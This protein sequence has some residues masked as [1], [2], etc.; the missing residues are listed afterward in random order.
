M[1]ALYYPAWDQLEMRDVPEPKPQAGEVVLRVL[2]VGICGSELH[3][4]VAHAA[5]RTP[6]LIMGH[7]FSGEITDLGP[8]VTEFRVGDRVVA[9]SQIA[10][11]RCEYCLDGEPQLC[12]NGEVFGTKRPGAFA[13]KV[14]VPVST[15][16]PLP[17]DVTPLQASLAE[18][19]GNAVHVLRLTRQRF[20]ETA[21]VF[22]AG[23]IGLFVLQVL[24][25]SGALRVLVSDVSDAR[26]AVAKRLGADLTINA[27]KADIAAAARDASGGRGADVVVDA[28][29]ATATRRAAIS[30]A[31]AGGEI[32]WLG[33]HD[34]PTELSG[35]D[36]VLREKHVAGSF[37]VTHRDMRSA[38]ALF[39]AG[40][41]VLEPWVRAFP[42]AE[43]ARVF[44]QLVSAPPDDYIKAVLVPNG[45]R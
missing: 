24:K 2:A 28:V 42:L 3:G 39:G 5:R 43:G 35:F 30:A 9:S 25:A 32:V 19:L 8:G 18:P 27:L 16:M 11:G 21:V 14:A 37:A 6:P 13:E 29:G 17:K 38:L 45:T 26:L 41:I 4:F 12:R 31:R 36:V 33:L 10:C 1:Q 15:L 22:G 34:D 23:T 40:K 44:Q 20:P 7:E